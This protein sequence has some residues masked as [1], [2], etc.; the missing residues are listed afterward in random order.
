M[1]REQRHVP[2]GFAGEQAA[3]DAVCGASKELRSLDCRKSIF[4]ADLKIQ[5]CVPAGTGTLADTARVFVVTLCMPIA[6]ACT[7]DP[8]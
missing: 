8:V 5:C 4:C 6:L 1:I 7:P 3:D 2:V